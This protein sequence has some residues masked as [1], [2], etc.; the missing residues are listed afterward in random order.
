MASFGFQDFGSKDKQVARGNDGKTLC[1][2]YWRS[3]VAEALLHGEQALDCILG[4]DSPP[5]R[6]PDIRQLLRDVSN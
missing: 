2:E 5:V 6:H 1:K 3:G 4:I